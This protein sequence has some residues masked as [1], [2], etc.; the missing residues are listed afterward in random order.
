MFLCAL[1][2][3]NLSLYKVT[4]DGDCTVTYFLAKECSKNNLDNFDLSFAS[5][6]C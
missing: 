6:L 4:A 5:K 2:G 3:S 1:Y